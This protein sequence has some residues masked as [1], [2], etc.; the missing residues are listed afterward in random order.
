MCAASRVRIMLRNF[1]DF[2]RGNNAALHG[3]RK[4]ALPSLGISIRR[5]GEPGKAYTFA[6][7]VIDDIWGFD[8]SVFCITPRE[9]RQ[10]DPQQRL[11]LQLAWEALEDAGIPA[12]SIAKRNIGVY[13][14]ASSMDHG[15][16]QYFDPA[17]TDSYL[18]TGNTLSLIANRVSYQF[19]LTGPSL[20]IDT[21]CS[22][23]LVALDYAVQ[24]LKVGKIDAAIVG[25]VN[26]LLSP[27][28]FMGFCAATMLSPDGLCRAFDH[29][30]NGYVRSEGGVIMILQRKG[31]E[32]A[33]H[34]VHGEVLASGTN[35]DGRTSGVAL[36]SMQRQ[37]ELLRALYGASGIDPKRL[38]FVEAHGTGTPVGDPVECHALGKALGIPRRSPLP[39]GSAK[40][41]VG[42]LEPASGMVGL[43]KAQLALEHGVLPATLHVEALNPNIPFDDL[44]LKV[45]T[46]PISLTGIPTSRRIA[47]VT[48][49]GSAARTCTSSSARAA[50]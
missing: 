34:R 41:N 19:D 8:A 16:R 42:H 25:G 13:M 40:S 11:V 33:R 30:A 29:R 5:R 14:G 35:S 50:R 20:T 39:V 6:A 22:S 28:N 37:T 31:D 49:L 1:G 45:A 17:A 4:S 15:H 2:W 44:N 23:S 32:F 24:D 3:F 10:M 9:A 21:A 27:F 18:M 26:G 38:A 7:G 46:E 43:L 48:I 36:P 47:G 12:S